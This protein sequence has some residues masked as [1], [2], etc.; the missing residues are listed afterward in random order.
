MS[1][2]IYLGEDG[3]IYSIY[4][5]DQTYES[6]KAGT[7][8]TT[9]IAKKLRQDNQSVK[10]SIDLTRLG[11]THSAA[12]KIGVEFL[13]LLDFD[14]IAI[15]GNSVF[16]KHLVNFIITASGKSSTVKYFNSKEEAQAWLKSE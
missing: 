14:K 8:E 13:R 11:K 6:V 9:L 3:C 2:S 7:D 4:E 15:F 1:E 5:G 16:N 10:I 12:R